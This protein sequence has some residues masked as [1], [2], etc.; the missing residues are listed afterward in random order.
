MGQ[1]LGDARDMLRAARL[2]AAGFGF[3]VDVVFDQL[4]EAIA[5]KPFYV[6]NDEFIRAAMVIKSK[7]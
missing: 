7:A 1:Q 4:D 5:S 3:D 2:V 6:L